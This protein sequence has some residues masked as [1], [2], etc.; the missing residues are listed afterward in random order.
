MRISISERRKA[1]RFTEIFSFEY[2]ALR[3]GGEQEWVK[4]ETINVSEFGV[5]VACEEELFTD[6]V[7][8]VRFSVEAVEIN[9]FCDVIWCRKDEKTGVLSAGLEFEFIGER[10]I[11]AENESRNNL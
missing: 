8:R 1:P 7:L 2:K 5:C 9:A 6:E 3:G 11:I 10:E 4:T